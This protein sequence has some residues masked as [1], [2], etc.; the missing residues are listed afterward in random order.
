MKL[1]SNMFGPMRHSK[2]NPIVYSI[3]IA[4]IFTYVMFGFMARYM[5]IKANK[6]VG[7][8]L[9]GNFKDEPSSNYIYEIIVFTGNRLNSGT[10]SNVFIIPE[11]SAFSTGGSHFF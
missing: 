5:D 10:K 2:H 9:I 3:V 6:K 4:L 11:D 1:I 7:F 8:T